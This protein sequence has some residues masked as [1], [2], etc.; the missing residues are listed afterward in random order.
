MYYRI[1]ENESV[2]KIYALWNDLPNT[3]AAPA[4]TYV[5]LL[6]A[7]RRNEMLRPGTVD[8]SRWDRLKYDDN[9]NDDGEAAS[10]SPPQAPDPR[11]HAFTDRVLPILLAHDKGL[12]RALGSV[13][14]RRAGAQE[15]SNKVEMVLASSLRSGP[16][17]VSALRAAS[18]AN[19]LER[20]FALLSLLNKA[21]LSAVRAV[22][23]P[24]ETLLSVKRARVVRSINA[25]LSTAIAADE[26]MQAQAEAS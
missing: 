4:S 10:A 15:A 14:P 23:R 3:R 2:V 13:V 17:L 1:P 11:G 8:Y 22:A 25:Y 26:K 21:A 6:T 7:T 19:E 24:S 16:Q 18:A 20:A 9:E 5:T 12:L